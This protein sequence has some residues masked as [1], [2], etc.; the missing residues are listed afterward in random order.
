YVGAAAQEKVAKSG[1][2]RTARFVLF[3][4]HGFL[5]GE[6]LSS[7][8]AEGENEEGRAERVQAQPALALT[9]VGDLRGED[10]LLTMKEVIE[11][12]ELKA[13]LVSLSPCDPHA[14]SGA[15]A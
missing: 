6:Y 11:D 2:L 7:A 5:G 14:E 3:A 15:R 12:L 8:L 13:E 4:T 1:D 10:G 9:L